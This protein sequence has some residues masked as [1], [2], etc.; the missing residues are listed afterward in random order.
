MIIVGYRL[1]YVLSKKQNIEKFPLSDTYVCQ[2]RSEKSEL[3]AL[4]KSLR[5][6]ERERE[7]L[8]MHAASQRSTPLPFCCVQKQLKGNCKR[9]ANAFLF[10]FQLFLFNTIIIGAFIV[11]S[12]RFT[13]SL[14]HTYRQT[15]TDGLKLS[16]LLLQLH[17]SISSMISAAWLD[18]F[19]SFLAFFK[20]QNKSLAIQLFLNI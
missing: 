15:N 11:V 1:F 16:L 13:L 4:R 6:R 20:G 9:A 19:Q 14:S 12:C 8:L 10:F 17:S 5:D 3:A 2:I 7:A 18:N